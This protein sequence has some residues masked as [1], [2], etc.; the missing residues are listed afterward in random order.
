MPANSDG[1]L[2]E[3]DD[4]RFRQ[5]QGRELSAGLGVVVAG[6]CRD[7]DAPAQPF[8]DQEDDAIEHEEHGSRARLREHRAQ[9]V[10]EHQARDT[11][12][13]RAD[14]QQPRQPFVR[15]LDPPGP[16]RHQEASDDARPCLAV[17]HQQGERRSHM[18]R[19]E[20]REIEGLVG[21]LRLDDAVPAEPFGEQHRV[22]EARNRHQ[23]GHALEQADHDRLEIGDHPLKPILMV[24]R[25]T[26]WRPRFAD[27]LAWVRER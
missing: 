11:D 2:R 16:Q 5:S 27:R 24:R 10:L 1:G 4:A 3:A 22:T 21:R 23:F 9:G 19:D 18:Q 8:A 25:R 12:G 7:G 20:E 15:R 14:D 6:S 17:V 26:V 13:D